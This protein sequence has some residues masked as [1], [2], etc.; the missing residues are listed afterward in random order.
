MH[1][2][3]LSDLRVW[4]RSPGSSPPPGPI[5]PEHMGVPAV[6]RPGHAGEPR[7]RRR[8]VR[9]R[10]AQR[11]AGGRR[12]HHRRPDARRDGPPTC[13]TSRDLR[14]SG[15]QICVGAGYY[16]EGDDAPVGG[17]RRHRHRSACCATSSTTA[18][19]TGTAR[20]CSA[21]SAP[22]GPSPTPNGRWSAPPAGS[23]PTP[24]RRCTCTC[25]SAGR[26]V[27]PCS[28]FSSTRVWTRCAGIIG[29]LD[30]LWDEGYH[31]EI[32]QAGAILGY[33]TFG[34]EVFYGGPESVA[35][36]MS[37]GSAW[38]HGSSTRATPTTRHRLRRLVADQPAPQRWLRLHDHLFARIAP[39]LI[40]LAGG[41]EQV[42]ARSWSTPRDACSIGLD[43]DRTGFSPTR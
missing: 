39:R 37:S 30:E 21:R 9:G 2:H 5:G 29:H 32:A 36:R 15:V 22:V 14:R 8:R 40:E 4:S 41:D 13:R 17:Q 42:A 11:I 25:P 23:A 38:C 33:D 20:R 26:A 34:T 18:S 31:R 19:R 3:V 1:E 28:M 16:V 10:G 7:A 43:A 12:R 24:E 35:L 6:E 27:S